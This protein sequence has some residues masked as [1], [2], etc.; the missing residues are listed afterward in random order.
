[1]SVGGNKSQHQPTGKSGALAKIVVEAAATA[2]AMAA[3]VRA[4]LAAAV[5]VALPSA[6]VAADNVR[7]GG[8]RGG[9]ILCFLLTEI[10]FCFS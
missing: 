9:V 4:A 5:M 8:D 7:Q 6:E 1:M 2:V 10:N 3:V